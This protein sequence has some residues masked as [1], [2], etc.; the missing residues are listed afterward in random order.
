MGVKM[1]D[2]EHASQRALP[3]GSCG[4][5]T[6]RTGK[7]RKKRR[8]MVDYKNASRRTLQGGPCRG[9][10]PVECQKS[11]SRCNLITNVYFE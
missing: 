3:G 11:V 1:V 5:L 2:Y 10:I 6:L 4:G 9:L 7:E 8:T